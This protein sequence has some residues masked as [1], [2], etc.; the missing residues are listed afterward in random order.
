MLP[1][2][3]SKLVKALVVFWLFWAFVLAVV[4]PLTFILAIQAVALWFTFPLLMMT[5]PGP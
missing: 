2:V 3:M 4:F 5:R 1:L